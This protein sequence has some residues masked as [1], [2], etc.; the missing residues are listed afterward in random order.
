MGRRGY[1]SHSPS[2]LRSLV[3]SRFPESRAGIARIAA[4]TLAAALAAGCSTID[5]YLPT[6][7][8]FGVY[9]LDINQGNYLSQDMVDKLRAGQTKQQVRVMLGTPLVTSTFRD[10]RW[11]YI[12]EFARQGRVVE[13]RTFTVYFVD[14][15]L[16]RW[17]GDEMPQSVAELNRTAAEKSM[18]H[19]PSA[20][21]KGILGWFLD[22]FRT[23]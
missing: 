22:I 9:K 15:K 12:Y 6:A 4:L 7:R 21:D 8:S 10:S 5:T 2:K 16:A 11:D 13:H 18:G 14:D 19:L 1:N 3:P 17:E 20:D 23:K